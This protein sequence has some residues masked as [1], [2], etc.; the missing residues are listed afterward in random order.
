MSHKRKILI[1]CTDVR[2]DILKNYLDKEILI[3]SYACDNY[4]I[5]I[6]EFLNERRLRLKSYELV[7]PILSESRIAI[8]KSELFKKAAKKAKKI[9]VNDYGTLQLLSQENYTCRLGRLLF[10]Q[11]RDSRYAEVENRQVHIQYSALTELLIRK[12]CKFDSM[13]IDLVSKNM[14]IDRDLDIYI[15]YPLRLLSVTRI[16]EFCG[17]I[18]GQSVRF[19]EEK[20][21]NLEC[22]S[23]YIQV[24]NTSCVKRG[25]AVYEK[26]NEDYENI[27]K[28]QNLIV[29]ERI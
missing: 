11:Y 12:G 13:E 22:M 1:N 28:D 26:L 10:H 25:R 29:E 18:E 17:E 16:C 24:E 21:C 23:V 19:A 20:E 9:V 27:C 7:V 8:L 6:L 5:K 2:F 14:E 3:G 4:F 15:H